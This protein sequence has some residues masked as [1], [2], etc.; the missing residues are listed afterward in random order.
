MSIS[1]G[2]ARKAGPFTCNGVTTQFP[3]AFK[4]FAQADVLVVQT[5]TTPV[6]TT[7]TLTSQYTVALNAN[8]DSNPG[9]TVTMVMPPPVGYLITLG[10]NMQYTQSMVLTNAGGFFPTVLNDLADRLVIQIQQ[11]AEQMGRT[12]QVPFSTIGWAGSSI[13]N[14]LAQAAASAA[15]AAASA[16][17]A[18]TSALGM[19]SSVN[20]SAANAAAAAASAAAAVVSA[21]NAAA[22][23]QLALAAYLDLF[24]PNPSVMVTFTTRYGGGGAID[25]GTIVPANFPNETVLSRINLATDSNAVFNFGT[26]P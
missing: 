3:F 17:Q 2:A 15:S 7:Q 25:F 4:V 12:F 22:P 8:Q 20:A 6:D 5:D 23:S 11:L 9:G 13:T 18:A 1:S 10:S 21:N 24:Y 14:F 16:L 19:T 26:V